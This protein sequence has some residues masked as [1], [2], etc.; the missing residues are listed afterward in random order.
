[1]RRALRDRLVLVVLIDALGHRIVREHGAFDFLGGGTHPITS[2]CGYSSACMPSLL[3]GR[4]PVEHGHWAMFLR[5]PERS[6]FRR[7]R[8]LIRVLSDRLGR[9]G[10]TRRVIHRALQR[11]IRGYFNLYEVPPALLPH[12]DL[13]E[14]EYLFGPRALPPFETP[15]DVA[16]R[17]GVP[18]R[19]Y[20]WETSEENRRGAL[21][22]DL[23]RGDCGFLFY[24]SPLLDAVMHAYGTRGESTR[25]CLRDLEVFLREALVVAGRSYR[26]VRLVVFGDHGM[27]DV[28]AAHQ[29]FPVLRELDLRV[30]GECLP[31]VDSTMARF[32]YFRP[33]VR[34][35][36]E[37]R[38]SA[39]P[40]GRVLTDAECE[41]LG[42]LFPDRRYGETV[43]LADGGEVLVPSFMGLTVP[44]GM[45]GYHP[46]HVDSA[47]TLLTNFEPPEIRSILEIG[48]WLSREIAALAPGGAGGGDGA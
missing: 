23:R 5:D 25:R 24:Y 36:V 13:C 22:G 41:R 15:F 16:A 20:A 3:T 31:F 7:F 32:W 48:P 26:E 39:L 44:A 34:E 9:H 6:V 38:L 40:Y 12:F 14:K 21:L 28:H 33:G 19:S 10:F 18:W 35:R 37:T 17:L 11:R 27:A 29:I 1:M 4:L 47:T 43:F 45:H 46:E 42:I 2:V 30:P 8:F